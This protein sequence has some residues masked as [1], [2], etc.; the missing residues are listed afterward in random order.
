MKY[1]I[2]ID[3]IFVLLYCHFTYFS[4]LQTTLLSVFKLTIYILQFLWFLHLL[5]IL[6]MQKMFKNRM[7]LVLKYHSEHWNCNKLEVKIIAITL[8]KKL[9][10]ISRF[11][12]LFYFAPARRIHFIM[13][14]KN[15]IMST[16]ISQNFQQIHM[17]ETTCPSRQHRWMNNFLCQPKTQS[18]IQI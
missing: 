8:F 4:D 11:Q 9:A 15:F 2:L 16:Q 10:G 17:D 13:F 12:L 6:F 1:L 7:K 3:E 14:Y 5:K 18:T